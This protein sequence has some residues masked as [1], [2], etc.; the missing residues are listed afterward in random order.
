MNSSNLGYGASAIRNSNEGNHDNS[1]SS[2]SMSRL[3]TEKPSLSSASGRSKP[4]LVKVRKQIVSQQGR[5]S[6]LPESGVNPGFNPF[7]PVSESLDRGKDDRK[8]EGLHHR[9]HR[10]NLFPSDSFQESRN[11][12]DSG[13][14][15]S[16]HFKFGK[17]DN[18][19]F[20]FM[21]ANRSNSALNLN[22]E[23]RE[24]IGTG[25]VGKSL[26]EEMG[27]L[28]IGNEVK[29]AASS[30]NA[31]GRGNS[32][33]G[34]GS[35]NDKGVFVF[36]SSNRKGSS[37][38]GSTVSKIQ[39]DMRKLNIEGFGIGP[40]VEKT[41][42]ANLSSNLNDKN[43]PIPE[44]SNNIAGAFGRS[45]A[46]KLAGEINKLDIKDSGEV[47]GSEKTKAK[48]TFDFGRSKK[49]DDS[50]AG[51]SATTLLDHMKNLNIEVPGNGDGVE[52]TTEANLKTSDQ[53]SF[54][55]G[56][57]KSTA[58]SF[59]GSMETM[60]PNEMRKLNIGSGMGDSAGQTDI[61]ISSSRIF[62]REKQPGNFG[63]KVSHDPVDG[64]SIPTPVNYQAGVQGKSLDVGQVPPFETNDDTPL[65]GAAAPSS[66]FS[67]TG[68]GFPPVENVF[69]VPSMD[70]AAK[71]DEFSFIRTRD[72]LGTSHTD[73]GTPKR[74]ASGSSTGNLYVGLNQK[75]EFSAKGEA[76][77]DSGFK[78]R[79]GKFRQPTRVQQWPGKDFVSKESFSQENP[80]S[81][82]CYSPMDYS[83]YQET[84]AAEQCSR[85]TS[86]TSNE[87]FH[88]QNNHGLSYAHKTV[89]SD[90]TGEDL[91]AA[92]QRFDI[93]EIDRKFGELNEEGSG[94]C[95]QKSVGVECP[96][97]E[98]VSGAETESF[99]S[100]TEEVDISSNASVVSAET[101][102]GFN[103]NIEMQ[104]NDC[105]M[106]FCSAS[107]SQDIGDSNFTF[108]APSSAQGQFSAAKHH[109]RKNNR[110]KVGPDSCSSLPSA[111]VQFAS[112]SV[113]FSPHARTSLPLGSGQGQK[114]EFCISQSKGEKKFEADKEQDV[115]QGSISTVGATAAALEDCEKWRLRG[116]HAYVSGNLSKAEDY[117]TNGVNCVSPNE[118]SRSC[119]KALALCL[120]N[121]AATR[122]SLG[123]MREALGDCMMASAIDPN[124]LRVQVRAAK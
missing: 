103:S 25:S 117:Y 43:N 71:K 41:K 73:L 88:L 101:E 91:V 32:N 15:I 23:N 29:D 118:T 11:L 105:K 3:G 79:R 45:M 119:L 85:E 48:N 60:L 69:E 86:V 76:V 61:G 55:L 16:G 96:V 17:S 82:G 83:P 102:A 98:F 81:P 92:T 28:N 58:G 5:S 44:S 34:E 8:M 123:R 80:E 66:T 65:N 24:S 94:N 1:F 99:K 4:R 12:N 108:T 57:V 87:S 97:E 6:S 120:S 70:R 89:P 113:Q 68:H 47:N 78:K 27:K 40:G 39:E 18:A 112:S 37:F 46:S 56:S 84:L 115:K 38:V 100:E 59:G 53:G 114:G 110:I 10:S 26:Q 74:D 72:G 36:G 121:R 9:W 122:M 54:V 64:K 93:S 109:Y 21:G 2:P 52:K 90:A 35:D 63:D 75:L 62:V 19:D 50:F 67:S 13:A 107:S 20:V 104:E 77:K 95:F 49:A 124:F 33:L 42:G 7:P 111:K 14:S 51:S 30:F 22:L 116:N 106:Q 31:S